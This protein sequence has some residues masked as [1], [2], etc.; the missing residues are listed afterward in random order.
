MI[1]INWPVRMSYLPAGTLQWPSSPKT[2]ITV[3]ASQRPPNKLTWFDFPRILSVST[4]IEKR[5]GSSQNF[6]QLDMNKTGTKL[7]VGCVF[8]I[9]I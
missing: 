9:I 5:F 8:F 2:F 1:D 6:F 7:K 4:E 3:C